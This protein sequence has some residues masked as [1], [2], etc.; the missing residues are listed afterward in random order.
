[1]YTFTVPFTPALMLRLPVNTTLPP[2][3]VPA[4]VLL[5][6]FKITALAEVLVVVTSLATVKSSV[7][8]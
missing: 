8:V 4:A 5:A 7:K 3:A 6:A 1:M 2:V